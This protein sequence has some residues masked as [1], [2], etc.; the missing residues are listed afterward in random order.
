MEK[1]ESEVRWVI[2]FL[3][4]VYQCILAQ[5]P[6]V[7]LGHAGSEEPPN[8]LLY[9]HKQGVLANGYI[10]YWHGLG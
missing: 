6:V 3:E 9:K 8:L 7:E 2:P 5:L 10:V 1:A 4:H